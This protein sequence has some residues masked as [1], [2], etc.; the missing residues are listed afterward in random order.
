VL[1]SRIHEALGSRYEAMRS[2]EHRLSRS[3]TILGT[4][5]AENFVTDFNLVDASI[6]FIA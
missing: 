1:A 4:Q 6:D 5:A 3:E 2:G